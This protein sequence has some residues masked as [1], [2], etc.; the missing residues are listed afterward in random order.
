MSLDFMGTQA[1]DYKFIEFINNYKFYICQK[2]K[3]SNM[4]HS[5]TSKIKMTC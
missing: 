4:I 2:T 3:I 5:Y 1:D